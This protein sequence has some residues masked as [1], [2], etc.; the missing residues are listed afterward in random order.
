MHVANRAVRRACDHEDH[1]SLLRIYFLSL[2]L[3]VSLPAGRQWRER[4]PQMLV[5]RRRMM[6]IRAALA[7]AAGGVGWLARRC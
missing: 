3:S 6:M 5:T 7:S 1:I 4:R 2:F